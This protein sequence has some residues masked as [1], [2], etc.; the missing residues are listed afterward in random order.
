MIINAAGER[1]EQDRFRSTQPVSINAVWFWS[2]T[3]TG[4]PDCPSRIRRR[5]G[6]CYVGGKSHL[7]PQR[8]AGDHQFEYRTIKSISPYDVDRASVDE[9]PVAWTKPA[10]G[11]VR[12]GREW[13]GKNVHDASADKDVVSR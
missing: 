6:T 3:R 5:F 13:N 1:S 9:T 2:P 12:I 8:V 10:A 7:A 11:C 4:N